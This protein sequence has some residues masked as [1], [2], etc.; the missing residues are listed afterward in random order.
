M[1]HDF[2]R[3]KQVWLPKIVTCLLCW[4]MFFWKLRLHRS[5]TKSSRVTLVPIISIFAYLEG[6]SGQCLTTTL[7]QSLPHWPFSQLKMGP[8]TAPN[9]RSRWLAMRSHDSKSVTQK[10]WQFCFLEPKRQCMRPSVAGRHGSTAYLDLLRFPKKLLWGES[11]SSWR[12]LDTRCVQMRR[13]R[14]YSVDIMP[15]MPK[16]YSSHIVILVLLDWDFLILW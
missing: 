6:R 14:V 13:I 5:C 15:V 1:S 12:K 7:R 16:D 11:T 4:V 2:C 9:T 8:K 3:Y 10:L